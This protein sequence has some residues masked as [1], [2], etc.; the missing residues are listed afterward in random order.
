MK[1]GVWI[2]C[3]LAALLGV[4]LC[5]GLI[6]LI[7][8]GVWSLFALTQPVADGATDFL[9]LLGQGKTAEA[10]ASAGGVLRAQGDEASFTAAVKQL[11]LTDYVSASWNNR[12]LNNQSGSVEGTVTTKSGSAPAKVDLEFEQ[13]KWRVV[14]LQYGGRELA[15]LLTAQLPPDEELGRM[16]TEALKDLDEAVQG[17]DFT[18][19]HAKISDKWRQQVTAPQL[20]KFFQAFIDKGIVLAPAKDSIPQFDPP[21]AID[22]KSVLVLEGNYQTG[23]ALKV[24]FKLEYIHEATGWK[25]SGIHVN[26]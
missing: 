10:Y 2:G 11:G 18:A 13:G 6:A 9:S 1:K 17:K 25:L 23:I 12:H 19:L 20:Q 26:T 4:V 21:A 5:G 15:D 24:H 7:G 22:A 3:G 14:G 16:A 8:G